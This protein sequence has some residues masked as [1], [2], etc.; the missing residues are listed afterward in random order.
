MRKKNGT[1][2]W[3]VYLDSKLSRAQGRRIASNLAAPDVTVDMLAEAAGALSLE[4]EVLSDKRYPRVWHDTHPGYIV[5]R[6][7][8]HSKKR[9]LLMLAKQVR[10][11]VARR[12]AAEQQASQKRRKKRRR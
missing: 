2:V 3:P 6:S 11:I 5:V 1:I 10:R 4:Y 12:I 7:P 9:L 8:G